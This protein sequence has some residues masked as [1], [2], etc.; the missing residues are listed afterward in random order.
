[1]K[2]GMM[3]DFV[4]QE[5]GHEY[6]ELGNGRCYICNGNIIHIDEVG[7][8]AERYPEHLM[9]EDLSNEETE[10]LFEEEEEEEEEIS[11]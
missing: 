5:C 4:C 8:E 7:S 2:G 11:E 10:E 1:M 9:E 3:A 6:D